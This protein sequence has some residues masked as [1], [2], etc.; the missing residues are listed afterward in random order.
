MRKQISYYDPR[1]PE[2]EVV[3]G[4][5]MTVIANSQEEYDEIMLSITDPEREVTNIQEKEL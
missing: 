5:N 1:C 4:R 3:D 2:L